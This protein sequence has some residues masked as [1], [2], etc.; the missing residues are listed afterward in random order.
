MKLAILGMNSTALEAAVRFHLHGAQFTWFCEGK[1]PLTKNEE[2]T[3]LGLGLINQSS[4][5]SWENDYLNPLMSF[6]KSFH[7]IKTNSVLSI[8][9]R[10]L[11]LDEVPPKSSRFLD[12]FRIIYQVNPTQFIEEQKELN[13]ETYQRLSDEFVNSLQDHIEMYEDFDLVLDFRNLE[14]TN[15]IS[16][17]GRALG[18]KR[19]SNDYVIKSNEILSWTKNLT[20]QDDVREIALIGSNYLAAQT[21]IN[22]ETWLSD[23]RTR[24]FVISHEEDPFAEFLRIGESELVSKL[25]NLLKAMDEQFEREVDDFHAKLREWQGLDDF[26]Q[27]KKPRPVEPIPRLVFFSGHNASAVDQLIDKRRLFLTLEKPE[28]RSGKKQPENNLSDL[29]TIGV[30]RVIVAG[31]LSKKTIELHLNTNEKGFF[32]LN[33]LPIEIKSAWDQNLKLLKGIEDEI[34]LLFSPADTH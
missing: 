9:K 26:I 28:F 27:V 25:S 5:N 15:S 24:V 18:E 14:V 32:S 30:D 11:A 3:Q 1:L 17:T 20:I 33:I 6:L 2:V 21:L 22:L 4:I 23:L 12:L 29:K 34:F 7:R 16:V 31:N 10:Y 19:I 8:S 13:P